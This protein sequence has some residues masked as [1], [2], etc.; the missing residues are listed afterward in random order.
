MNWEPRI[1]CWFLIHKII[2][3]KNMTE[4]V[5]GLKH[6]INKFSIDFKE[7]HEWKHKCITEFCF[8]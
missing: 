7:E 4:D 5:I 1:A 6:R 2:I 8:S 3:S